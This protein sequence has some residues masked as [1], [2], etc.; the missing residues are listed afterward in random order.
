[1]AAIDELIKCRACAYGRRWRDEPSIRSRCAEKSR[2]LINRNKGAAWPAADL[3]D[4]NFPTGGRELGRPRRMGRGDI[5]SLAAWNVNMSWKKCRRG[6]ISGSI[7][8]PPPHLIL[9][10]SILHPFQ[11]SFSMRASIQSSLFLLMFSHSRTLA[12][13]MVYYLTGGGRMIKYHHRR[14]DSRTRQVIYQCLLFFF[15]KKTIQ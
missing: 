14:R 2:H 11:Q 3:K 9:P 12:T 4:I 15:Q 10:P 7:D 5:I 13:R 6:G 1:M 8:L